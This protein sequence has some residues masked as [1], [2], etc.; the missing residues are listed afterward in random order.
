MANHWALFK[1]FLVMSSSDIRLYIACSFL[2][3][4]INRTLMYSFVIQTRNK[5]REVHIILPC[6]QWYILSFCS[7]CCQLGGFYNIC[8]DWPHAN[9]RKSVCCSR[10]VHVSESML[11][12]VLL[13]RCDVPQRGFC[14]REATTGKDF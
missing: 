9:C 1:T 4:K 7:V 13:S 14:V 10:T 8:Y 11:H 3:E 12:F 2:W 5:S 6:Y